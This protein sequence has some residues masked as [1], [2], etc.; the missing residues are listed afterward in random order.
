MPCPLMI[1][2]NPSPKFAD[3]PWHLDAESTRIVAEF[4]LGDPEMTWCLDYGLEMD[5]LNGT[6]PPRVDGEIV[7]DEVEAGSRLES[8]AQ[9]GRLTGRDI[10]L[11][12]VAVAKVFCAWSEIEPLDNRSGKQRRTSSKVRGGELSLFRLPHPGRILRL[13]EKDSGQLEWT[14]RW[15]ATVGGLYRDGEAI[16]LAEV[17]EIDSQIMQEDQK[18]ID[19]LII[20]DSNMLFEMEEACEMREYRLSLL[21]EES[22]NHKRESEETEYDELN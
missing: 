13:R 8:W 4:A 20:H 11:V 19:E 5:N 2:M 9:N 7:I 3:E 21:R 17:R 12:G 10:V 6:I 16:N 1:G 14:E 22:E 15:F 18:V